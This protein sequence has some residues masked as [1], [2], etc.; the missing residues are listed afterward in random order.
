MVLSRD[1]DA[2]PLDASA[3]ASARG[4]ARSLRL[5][6]ERAGLSLPAAAERAGLG[7]LDIE[8]L[9]SGAL[10]RLPDR[11]ATLRS[12]RSYADSLGLP[13]DD[14]VLAAVE[15]WPVSA[16]VPRPG[17][18]GALP[19]VSVSSAPAGGHS[20][21]GVWPG[22]STGV[23]DFTITGVVGV[24]MA[25]ASND[26]GQVP[27]YDTGEVPAIGSSV[28]TV[29]KVLVS[30]VALLVV[31]GAVGLAEHSH[32]SGWGKKTQADASHWYADAKRAVGLAPKAAAAGHHTTSASAIPKV[33]IVQSTA[34]NAVT[35]VIHASSFVV[36]IAAVNAPCWV[37]ATDVDHL[38]PVFSAVLPSNQSHSFTV[39]QSTTIETASSSGRAYVYWHNRFIGFYF[40][41]KVPFTMTFNAVG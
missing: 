31:L 38:E 27:I 2:S 1:D 30:I 4:I 7:A 6:R 32:L 15:L 23:T 26:T 33:T 28:P 25:P 18:T 19:V 35:F 12:L 9:E 24:A 20:P 16:P 14:Y 8:S 29:L 10:G 13:G 5:A 37:Q 39:T 11:V 41:K 17:D 34:T 40:P 3:P 22:D 36:K 21:A